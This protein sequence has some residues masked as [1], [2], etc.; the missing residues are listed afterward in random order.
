MELERV[1]SEVFVEDLALQ[2]AYRVTNWLTED[3]KGEIT[4]IFSSDFNFSFEKDSRSVLLDV[5]VEGETCW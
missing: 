2:I 5:E 3:I 4:D 1:H